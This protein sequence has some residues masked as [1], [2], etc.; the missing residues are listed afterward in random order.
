[1]LLHESLVKFVWR[2]SKRL[3]LDD[4]PFASLLS[5]PYVKINLSFLGHLHSFLF[6]LPPIVV[7]HLFLSYI[8]EESLDWCLVFTDGPVSTDSAGYAVCIPNFH[9]S[10][11]DVFNCYSSSFYT[12]LHAIIQALLIIQTLPPDKFLVVSDFQYSSSICYCAQSF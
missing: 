2:S 3:F 7:N 1:V 9:I 4:V 5:S 12:E 11:S 10:F 8:A 6:N